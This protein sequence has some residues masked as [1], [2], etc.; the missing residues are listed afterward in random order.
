MSNGYPKKKVYVKTFV[1]TS[2]TQIDKE[3]NAFRENN[4]VIAIQT[5]IALGHNTNLPLF[6]YVVFYKEPVKK[7]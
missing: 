3:V 1:G 4:D 6:H 5:N 2:P 7:K